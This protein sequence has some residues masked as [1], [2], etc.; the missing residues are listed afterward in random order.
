MAI[1][2]D[3]R[4]VVETPARQRGRLVPMGIIVTGISAGL[5]GIHPGGYI[6]LLL[7]LVG[8]VFFAPITVALLLRMVRNRPVLIL[9]ADGFTDHG[10]L[11]SAGYVPWRD[12]QRIEERPFGRRIFVAV[13][14]A[15]PEAFR[16]RQPA[17]RRLLYRINGR[18]AAGDIFIP[19]NV[20]P[21]SPTELARTMRRLHRAA[22]RRPRSGGTGRRN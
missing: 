17:W 9:D 10:S 13:T 15:D 3:E 8:V 20:L 4:I 1:Q 5:I 19:D 18:T 7:G 11:I 21:M 12:V 2:S 22:Q 6:G 14:V 16:A